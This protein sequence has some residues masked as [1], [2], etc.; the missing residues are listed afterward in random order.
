MTVVVVV[1]KADLASNLVVEDELERQRWQ[2]LLIEAKSQIS[3][4]WPFD[5]DLH[6]SMARA[7]S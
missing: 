3:P 2:R 4:R 1:E 6:H 7:K 5:R